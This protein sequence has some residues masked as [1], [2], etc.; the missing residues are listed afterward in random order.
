MYW[1]LGRMDIELKS[2]IG[3]EEDLP[4][5]IRTMCKMNPTVTNGTSF[6]Y[7]VGKEVLLKICA[8]RTAKGEINRIAIRCAGDVMSVLEVMHIIKESTTTQLK[9]IVKY[10]YVEIMPLL[11]PDDWY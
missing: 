4:K 3:E 7:H 8:R 1:Y 10:V 6:F 11:S 2:T 9:E 5:V